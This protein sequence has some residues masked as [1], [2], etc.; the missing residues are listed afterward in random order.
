MPFRLAFRMLRRSP[1]FALTAIST[2]A[3]ATSLAA[4]VFA[5]VDGVLFKRLP[6]HDP[7]RL[8]LV[9]R[10]LED[11]AKAE[12][13][14]LAT[15]RSGIQFSAEDLEAWRAA[16][17]GIAIA[18]FVANFG[19]GPVA[20]IDV[21]AETTWAA[22]V[23]RA[24][25][26]VLGMRPM[27]GGF[28]DED[29]RRPFASGKLTAHPA[30]ISYRLWQRIGGVPSGLPQALLQTG[31]GTLDVVGVLPPEFVFPAA[32]GRTTPDVL[33]PLDVVPNQRGLS[34]VGRLGPGVTATEMRARLHGV[35]LEPIAAALGAR[36][37][38]AFRMTL[39]AVVAVVLLGSLNVAMLL[40]ARR[41]DRAGELAVRTALGA[42]TAQLLQLLIA[43]VTVIAAAGTLVGVAVARPM[44]DAVLALLPAGYL[45][46][47]PPAIDARVFT[48]ALLM[49][50]ATLLMLT[51]WPALR[52]ARSS[53]YSEIRASVGATRMAARWRGV[54]LAAQSAI[55]IL[56]VLSGTLLLAGFGKLW[57]ENA[58][59]DRERTA[60]VDVTARAVHD[61][62]QRMALLDEVLNISKRVPGVVRA[63][64]LGGSF[65]R[66]AIGGSVFN[67]PAGAPEVLAQDV[68]V[69]PGLFETA[70]ILL[71]TGRLLT[72]DEIESGH[73]VAVVSDDLARAYWPRGDALGQ[74][75]SSPR[76]TVTVVGIVSDVRIVGLEERQRTAEIYVPAAVAGPRRDRTIVLR[77]TGDPDD[78]ARA[79]AAEIRQNLPQVMITRAESVESALAGTVRARQFQAVL[80]GTFALA[81]LVLL[82]V[83]IVGVVGMN[84]AARQREIGVRMALGATAA[85]VSRMIVRENLI[86]VVAGLAAGVLGAQW[87][88]ASL[89][90]LIYGVSPHDSRLLALSASFVLR[91]ALVAAWLPA[92]RAGRV[93]PQTVL[94]A[95]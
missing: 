54:A 38:P 37:R 71:L 18:A 2:V 67:A 25:F 36:E 42:S 56:V 69:S 81:T 87:T 35:V 64:A 10:A 94:R 85:R 76:G 47:K 57:R 24:F 26:D 17:A 53:A 75:L 41:R 20:G 89:A 66:N 39:A 29:Y 83:G 50:T 82:A 74:V 51:L 3:L 34:G 90:S 43:E 80:F 91:T 61:S 15:G 92:R 21:S 28:R 93:D 12:Q 44:L 8:V 86:P 6:Y 23:D 11:P 52:A 60:V 46:I 7:D 70:G 22:R 49:A 16:N 65:L 14:R 48:F 32:F 77:T 95:Q 79:V 31:D 72:D 9:F 58:G 62:T 40:S 59:M 45:L 19:L 27:I 78:V 30:I 68:P 84:T 5:V 33:L 55:G 1:W 73:P 13:L 63:S 88:T 4:T